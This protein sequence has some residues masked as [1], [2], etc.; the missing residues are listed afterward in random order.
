VSE[1]QSGFGQAVAELREAWRDL[2]G[3]IRA[4]GRDIGTEGRTIL[5]ELDAPTDE[6]PNLWRRSWRRFR[7]TPTPV[8]IVVGLLFFAGWTYL[9]YLY[10][11]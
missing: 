9:V 7:H 2:V 8:Q 5:G 6:T 10:F 1:R 3:G 11:R 4:T